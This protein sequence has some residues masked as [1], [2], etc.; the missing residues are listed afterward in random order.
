VRAPFGDKVSSFMGEKA[1]GR[2]RRESRGRGYDLAQFSPS[3]RGHS[4]AALR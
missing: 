1:R 2:A 4:S 3:Q